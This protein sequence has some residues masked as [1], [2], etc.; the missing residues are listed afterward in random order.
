MLTIIPDKVSS[1]DKIYY[2]EI[3]NVCDTVR[4]KFPLKNNCIYV[5]NILIILTDKV[6]KLTGTYNNRVN[7]KTN[8]IN[9]IIDTSGSFCCKCHAFYTMNP[10]ILFSSTD[11]QH[12]RYFNINFNTFK[13]LDWIVRLDIEKFNIPKL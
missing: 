10:E 5:F 12:H 1:I 9:T 2:A 6:K 7:V 11:T 8:N 3:K 4:I 13:C